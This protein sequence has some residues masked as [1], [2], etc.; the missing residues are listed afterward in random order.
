M[1]SS[2]EKNAEVSDT[3]SVNDLRDIETTEKHL[4]YLEDGKKLKKKLKAR[5]ITM[6]AIGGAL[7]T[8]LIIGTG[9]ALAAAGPGS[10]FLAYVLVGFIVYDVMCALGEMAAYIPLP[11]GFTGYAHRYVDPALGFAVGWMY[12]LKYLLVCPNQLTAGALVMQYWVHRDKINP[13]VWITIFLVTITAIN[14][15]GVQ[16]FGEIEFWLSCLKVLTCVGLIFFLFILMLGGGPNG[17][18]TGFRYWKDPGAFKAYDGIEGSTGRFVAFVSVLVTAVFAFLGTELVG[19]TFGEAQNVKAIPKAIKLTFWRIALFYW[20][21]VLFLGCCVAY[22]DPNLAFANKQ[23]SSAA[24]S[25]FVVAAISAG[26]SGLPHL[27]NGCILVFIFSASN[28]DLYLASRALYG[29]SC[30]EDAPKFFA[31]TN[32]YGVPV[33][34]LGVAVVFA[35]LAYMNVT[36]DSKVLF[37]YFV[38]VVSIFGLICWAT[39]I[40]CHMYFMRALITQGVDRN[41]LLYKAPLQPWADYVS[42]FFIILICLIKNFTVF[43]FGDFKYK[44]FITGYIGIPVFFV[45]WLGYKFIYKTKVIKAED[46]DLYSYRDIILAEQEEHERLEKEEALARGDKKN[47]KWFYY[48]FVAWLF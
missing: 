20:L 44:T 31:R 34:A 40:I 25:P 24:A 39:I 8:G 45:L 18:R 30:N 41:T 27:I 12:L 36:D 38:S 35:L 42:L 33:Y 4:V 11:D 16:K 1:G 14:F 17:D 22:D 37:G 32:K 26:I 48:K 28:S 43:L 7:G 19:I 21:N 23:K 47:A 2:V 29:L 5:H 3:K 13:G 9:S 15:F 10:V 46:V 6:I